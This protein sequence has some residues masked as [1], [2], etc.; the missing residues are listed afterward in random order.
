MTVEL[1]TQSPR[2]SHF[3]ILKP[4]L[5]QFNIFLHS[6]NKT[7]PIYT[8]LK[9]LS[10]SFFRT[11]NSPLMSDLKRVPLLPLNTNIPKCLDLDTN[12]KPEPDSSE[13]ENPVPAPSPGSVSLKG[14][15]PQPY[16]PKNPLSKGPLKSSS[17]QMC[18]KLNEED[19]GLKLPDPV[20]HSSD[21]WEFSDSESAPASSWSTLPNR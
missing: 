15:R 3:Q 1:Q 4:F 5:P 8:T 11:R 17:L 6:N 14:R 16:A 18:M 10:F 21:I 7:E 13:K 9:F 20:P 2:I 12:A 19:P